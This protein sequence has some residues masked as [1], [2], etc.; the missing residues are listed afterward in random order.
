MIYKRWEKHFV[1]SSQL[2]PLCLRFT[3]N[4]FLDIFLLRLE[5]GLWS[6]PAFYYASLEQSKVFVFWVSRWCWDRFENFL[7][8]DDKAEKC[9]P[10]LCLNGQKKGIIFNAISNGVWDNCSIMELP[11]FSWQLITSLFEWKAMRF[12]R[13]NQYLFRF[14]GPFHSDAFDA[15][16][17]QL[18]IRTFL[19]HPAAAAA[20]LDTAAIM[21]ATM[22]E[23]SWKMVS[24]WTILSWSLSAW[25]SV[26]VIGKLEWFWTLSA[27]SFERSPFL[28]V[29][30]ELAMLL[31]MDIATTWSKVSLYC[32][33][34]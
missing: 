28:L 25:E 7:D 6:N 4:A 18:K 1:N 16:K 21:P 30:A 33:H 24:H 26:G 27:D 10:L 11:S 19:M 3:N 8:A 34:C 31:A 17:K 2:S 22:C 14:F 13:E 12:K 23:W 5:R 15:Q 9:L 32:F 29:N 20:C